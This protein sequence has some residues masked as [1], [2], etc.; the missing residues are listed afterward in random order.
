[1]LIDLKGKM[2]LV[3]GGSV[4]I[5]RAIAHTLGNCGARVALTYLTHPEAGEQVAQE[6]RNNGGEAYAY[7]LDVTQSVEVQQ[8]VDRVVKDFGAPLDILVNNAGHLIE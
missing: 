2:A 3:T 8:V 7:T 6:I 1:M 4:G 5:G